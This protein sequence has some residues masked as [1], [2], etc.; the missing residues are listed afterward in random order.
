MFGSLVIVLPTIHEGGA[1]VL[2]HGGNEWTFDSAKELSE[3]SQPSIGYVAFYSDVEHE[4]TLVK[5]GYRV[6]LTYNLYFSTNDADDKL[7]VALPVNYAVS[8]NEAAF[9][10]ALS[11]LLADESVLPMGGTLGFGLHHEYP[12]NINTKLT[13]LNDRL[14][15]SDAIVKRACNQLSLVTSLK[16]MYQENNYSRV[17]NIMTDRFVDLSKR[18]EVES[19][20]EALSNSKYGGVAVYSSGHR[21]P[22]NEKYD[23][24]TKQ[25]VKEKPVEIYWATKLTKVTTLKKEFVAYGNQAELAYLYGRVF[26][27]AQ[28]GP[29]G[30]RTEI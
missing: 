9:T 7:A 25:W 27:T 1:L 26:L 21:A 28:V 10:A 4:V 17:T 6:T 19:V 23:R 8:A 22:E 12:V 30:H 2:C 20:W 5:S 18:G 3:Q 24:T 15:G 11:D 29:P 16:V 14:K 13:T